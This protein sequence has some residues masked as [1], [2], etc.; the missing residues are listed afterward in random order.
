MQSST[1]LCVWL[2]NV[3]FKGGFTEGKEYLRNCLYFQNNENDIIL[4]G[5]IFTVFM[6]TVIFVW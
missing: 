4:L 1:V 6:C 3:V 5:V 2:Y